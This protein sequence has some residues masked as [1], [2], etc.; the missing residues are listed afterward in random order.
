MW[1]TTYT[2]SISANISVGTSVA[3]LSL[4]GVRR[5]ETER[6]R[7]SGREVEREKHKMSR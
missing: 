7:E 5:E 3:T 4:E 2:G 1:N 6:G